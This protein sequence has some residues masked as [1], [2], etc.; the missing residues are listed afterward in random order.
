MLLAWAFSQCERNAWFPSTCSKWYCTNISQLLLSDDANRLRAVDV[1]NK[2][3]AT[4]KVAVSVVSTDF[5]LCPYSQVFYLYWWFATLIVSF[6]LHKGCYSLC[7]HLGPMTHHVGNKKNK[8]SIIRRLLMLTPLPNWL[9][10]T[11]KE[12][13]CR[14]QSYWKVDKKCFGNNYFRMQGVTGFSLAP[15]SVFFC[16][17]FFLKSLLTS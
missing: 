2:A 11:F 15:F 7:Y 17:F 9:K 3:E 16:L 6:P 13:N 8:I 10:F 5:F 1:A 14:L 12:G 4:R